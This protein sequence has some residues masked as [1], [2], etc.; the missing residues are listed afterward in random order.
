MA[1]AHGS[2]I[3]A[4]AE[5]MYSRTTGEFLNKRKNLLKL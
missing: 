5:E 2:G 1:L 4:D 3:G